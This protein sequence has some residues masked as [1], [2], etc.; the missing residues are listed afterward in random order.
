MKALWEL[1]AERLL[2]LPSRSSIE[3]KQKNKDRW[4]DKENWEVEK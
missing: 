1:E 3:K 4:K 2:S